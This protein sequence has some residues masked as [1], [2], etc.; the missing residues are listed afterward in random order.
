MDFFRIATK[1]AR[2]GVIEVSP[3]FIVGRSKDLMIQGN[4]FYAI[5]NEALG[6]WSR[7]EYDVVALVDRELNAYA[8]KLREDGVS[9]N[10]KHLDSFGSQGWKQFKAFM[11]SVADNSK[12]LDNKVVF[13]NTPVKKTDYV[14]RRLPY[15]LAEGSIAAYE[16]LV[17]LLYTPEERAKFEWAIGSVLAGDAKKIEK[18]LVFF[19]APGTGKSTVM[20]IAS[21][22]LGGLVDAGGY[23]ETFD[24]KALVGNN[25]QFATEAFKNNP[26]LA[27]QHDTDL[28][29]IS[30]NSTLNSIVSKEVLRVNEKYKSTYNT[31]IIAFLFVGTN[32]PVRFTDGK[33]GMIRRLIDVNPTGVKHEVNRYNTLVQQIDFEL[34]AIAHHCLTVYRSMGKNFY[35]SYKPVSMML[36]TDEFFNFVEA[37]FDI[38]KEQDSTTLK[39]AYALYKVYCTDAAIEKPLAMYKFRDELKNYFSE[40]I[41]RKYVD[42]AEVKSYYLG[43]T[44]MPYKTTLKG[45]PTTFS[46]VIDETTS[47][48]DTTYADLPAQYAKADETPSQKWENV[49]KT[50]GDMDTSRVHFVKV[51]ENH[52]VIDFDLKDD[53][54]QK[55]LE[56]N[57]EAASQWPPT[58]AELSKSGGGVH[59]H[60]LYDGGDAANLASLYSEGIEIKVFRGG[61]SLRRK[62]SRS[63]AVPVASISS[64]LP[65]KEEKPV[66]DAKTLQSEKGLRNLI[67]RNLNK[68]IHP[69]TKPSVEFIGK[70]L[71]DAF[72]SEMPY[73]VTDMR[74]RIMAFANNSTNHAPVCLKAV[75]KMKFKSEIASG[76]IP[77]VRNGVGVPIVVFDCEVYPNLF[78]ICWKYKGESNMT[79]MINPT[80]A[81][82]ERLFQFRLIGFNN[83]KYDNHILW[84]RMLGYNNYQLFQ[85]SQKLIAAGFNSKDAAFG[86]AYSVSYADIYDFATKKQSLKKWGIEL[87]MHHMEMDLPWDEPVPDDKVDEVVEY[88]VNDVLITEATLDHLDADFLSR[89]IIAEMSGL[90][91]N[92]TTRM[93]AGRIIFGNVKDPQK[94]FVYTDLREMFPGYE[95]DP[96]SK[97]DKSTY[98][99][100]VVGEGGYVYAEAG[101]YED[102]ALLDVASMHPTSIIELNLFGPY[103]E[104]FANLYNGRLAI[105]GAIHAWKKGFNDE[106]SRLLNEATRCLPGLSVT[107]DNAK[108]LSDALKLV[109]NSVYGYTS[110]RFPNLFRD[111]RNVD[112]IVAKRGAL[113]MIDL[114]NYIQSL[115][116]QVAHIKTDSVKIPGADADIIQ[117]VMDFGRRYGYE[118]EHEKTFDKI[119]LVNDAVYI[120]YVQDE[121]WTATGAQFAHPVVFKALFSG[122]PLTFEDLCET[123]SVQSPSAMYLDFGKG[124]PTPANPTDGMHFIGRTGRFL[125]VY[126]SSGGARLYRVKE[127]RLYAITG[128]KDHHW[129]ESEM[130]KQKEW[131]ALEKMK[132]ED[133]TDAVMGNGSLVDVVDMSYYEELVFEAQEAISKFGDFHQF[134]K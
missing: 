20:N 115:G 66:I 102:V 77:G 57:L 117:K 13:A 72:A 71:E 16:E 75:Q 118:F 23:V 33:S 55:S 92:D 101:M 69:G 79:R 124:E 64:G 34:G 105:K 128:T 28:S 104:K 88:C 15:E 3:D 42:G 60:Y 49:T 121:G 95:F 96:Y 89:Q 130:V 12:P 56:R 127:G 65:L 11:K 14:S 123:K 2:G 24:A 93:H 113:F 106:A 25:N 81:E 119:C 32:N 38:F 98:R 131:K 125:P 35:N 111:N 116:Y 103:T 112:N 83:R 110:A 74:P 29:R 36:R 100:E 80:P 61:S 76:E 90:T 78:V 108:A 37:H 18:W 52:I 4:A 27:I 43:F 82:V 132:F 17:S 109:L 133:I 31:R 59:L 126:Q 67:E 87:G 58:Y 54:G 94:D 19:G 46:L 1:E 40:F 45:D 120:A 5:W 44:A 53:N 129:L 68:E 9:C 26:L 48:F 21:K 73:D 22:M 51:P 7:D 41:D 62:L 39:Q 8:D 30:D 47:V 84:G 91:I 63:N 107:K 50:L 6:L 10:V 122:E 134:V 97:L 114:K 70:I 86:E 85:L 99:G